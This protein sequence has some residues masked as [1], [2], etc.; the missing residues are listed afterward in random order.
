MNISIDFDK[1]NS[2]LE[3]K[4]IIKKSIII[5][6]LMLNLS[7]LLFKDLINN[8]AKLLLASAG[9]LFS[10][11]NLKLPSSEYEE[12][13]LKT[14]KDSSIKKHKLILTGE[15]ARINSE[16]EIKNQIELANSIE[17]LPDYQIPYFA[18]KYG[19]SSIISNN[20]ISQNQSIKN[21]EISEINVNKSIFINKI[22]HHEIESNSNLNWIKKA[23]DSSCFIAGKKRSGKTFF[24]K[25]LLSAYIEKSRDIDL[26]YISDP[27]YDM[28]FEDP[29]INPEIDKKLIENKRLVKGENETLSMINDVI[30]CGENRKK[31]GLTIKKNVGLIRLFLDEIDSYSSDIQSEISQAIRKIEYE[32]AKYGIT[33]VLGCHSIKK[34]ENGL[35]SSVI[36]SM[37]N[38]LFPTIVLDRNSILSGIFP[39]IPKIK[40]MI[41]RYKNEF[42]PKDGRI[43]AIAD[44]SEFL[45]SHIPKLDLIPIKI[46]EDESKSND[47]NPIDKIKKW[48]DLCYEKFNRYPSKELIKKAWFDYTGKDL[49]DNALSLLIE[50]LNIKID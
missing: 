13:L 50:K 17:N 46:N 30:N 38:I 45:I 28:D 32:F 14:Y 37:M 20:Y 48:S 8:N 5:S 43:V 23:I 12:K 10:L 6:S 36:S 19:V 3:L 9:F 47:D 18:S 7:P 40:N 29:W 39:S 31:L 26:F 33:I 42:L 15:I 4:K 44:D 16:I 2:S 11:S 41:D 49:S 25:F 24:M 27:H 22:E 1:V 35:D 34:S 21:D